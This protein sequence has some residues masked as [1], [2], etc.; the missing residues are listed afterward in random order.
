MIRQELHF[1]PYEY[2]FGDGA[3]SP[4]K[5]TLVSPELIEGHP[6][7]IPSI[8]RPQGSAEYDF[9]NLALPLGWQEAGDF[10][11][12]INWDQ[13]QKLL[14][15]RCKP[16]YFPTGEITVD[17]TTG[18]LIAVEL[19]D[20]YQ[21]GSVRAYLGND[22]QYHA[23]GLKDVRAAVPLMGA[24][25]GFLNNINHF[26]GDIRRY[27]TIDGERGRYHSRDLCIPDTCFEGEEVVT[28]K[29]YQ[30]SFRQRANDISGQF[31][32][33]IGPLRFDERG[34]LAYFCLKYGDATSYFLNDSFGGY[35]YNP[36]NV[37]G[38][39]E[40]AALHGIAAAF[41]NDML[42]AGHTSTPLG[43]YDGK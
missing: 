26:R 6:Y 9:L 11:S 18:L 4:P 37:F 20:H 10:L 3:S 8:I 21:K 35:T 41:V 43:T 23:Q 31:D 25:T 34:I 28:T 29:E 39:K 24:V 14:E 30:S 22:G 2:P 5:D 40:A 42:D 7:R 13:E 1:S 15:I 33:T 12:I 27:A 19:P 32:N 38:V 36:H 17:E 16:V